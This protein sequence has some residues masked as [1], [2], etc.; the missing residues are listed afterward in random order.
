MKKI[1]PLM[2]LFLALFGCVKSEEFHAAVNR[3]DFETVNRML[4][5]NPRL[6]YSTDKWGGTPLHRAAGTKKS[7]MTQLLIDR[8]ADV[9]KKSKDGTT[10]LHWAVDN[11]DPRPVVILCENG[12]DLSI[13]SK[14]GLT[15]IN[16][17]RRNSFDNIV[18]V[19]QQYE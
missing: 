15:P 17:A 10:P 12:A 4:D 11:T 13:K 7:E 9:N 2:I 19:L 16:R 6:I 14:D 18:R 3:N 8:G 1:I 5:E